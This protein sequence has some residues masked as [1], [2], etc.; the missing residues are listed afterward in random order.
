MR[1]DYAILLYTFY[2]IIIISV[3]D[4]AEDRRRLSLLSVAD[5]LPKRNTWLLL[6]LLYYEYIT[7]LPRAVVGNHYRRAARSRASTI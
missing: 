7:R 2:V 1:D 4:N 3:Y 6:L 5:V